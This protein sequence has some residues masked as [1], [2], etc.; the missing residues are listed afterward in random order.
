M[1]AEHRSVHPIH[2]LMYFCLELVGCCSYSLLTRKTPRWMWPLL[3]LFLGVR[4]P[5]IQ[6]LLSWSNVLEVVDNLASGQIRTKYFPASAAPCSNTLLQQGTRS[7]SQQLAHTVFTSLGNKCALIT[8]L[9]RHD[10]S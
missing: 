5:I 9:A 3:S 10:P 1:E 4:A 7:V 8:F 6:V 2:A